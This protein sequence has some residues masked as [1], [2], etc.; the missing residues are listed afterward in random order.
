MPDPV[1]TL[2]RSAQ[3]SDRVRAAAWDAFQQAASADELAKQLIPPYWV[4]PAQQL[5][6][7]R[8]MHRW[9]W[10]LRRTRPH[11]PRYGY[12]ISA[13]PHATVRTPEGARVPPATYT[14]KLI[15]DGQTFTTKIEVLL[16]PRIVLPA[17]VVSQQNKLETQLADLLD[18]VSAATLEAQSVVDQL[19]K[20]SSKDSALANRIA[21]AKAKVTTLL[22]GGKH[23]HGDPDVPAL[24][25]AARDVADLYARV[26][27]DAAPTTAQLAAARAYDREVTTLLASWSAFQSK[28]LAQLQT[29]LAAAQLPAIDPKKEPTTEQAGGDEE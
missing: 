17:I 18:R 23:E 25:G 9:I 15:V 8:G 13:A 16:D 2:L 7:T 4:M 3:A 28:H 22:T 29:A 10:D 5:G 14:V 21:D 20:L 12:P 1:E 11:A 19:A 27:V 24:A 6:K 26:Q